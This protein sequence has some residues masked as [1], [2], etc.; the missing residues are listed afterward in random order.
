MISK[1]YISGSSIHVVIDVFSVMAAN[2]AANMAS[3]CGHVCGH[4]TE[5]IYND[6]YA[7]TRNVILA[8]HRL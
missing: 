3:I 8:N 6:M 5:N 1:N 7:G 4:D 2:L